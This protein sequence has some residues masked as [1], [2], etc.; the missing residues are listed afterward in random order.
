MINNRLV[1]CN[2]PPY[3]FHAPDYTSNPLP[4]PNTSFGTHTRT[5]PSLSLTQQFP[6]TWSILTKWVEDWADFTYT[7]YRGLGSHRTMTFSSYCTHTVSSSV[8]YLEQRQVKV[9]AMRKQSWFDGSW[10]Q[11][12]CELAQISRPSDMYRAVCFQ[13]S[14]VCRCFNSKS[15]QIN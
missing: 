14:T 7:E 11:L 8:A 10:V 6:N 13:L 9:S 3:S 5:L 15:C 1:T 2:E 12:S 4:F